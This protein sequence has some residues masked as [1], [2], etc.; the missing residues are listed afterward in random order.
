MYRT[1]FLLITVLSIH[2]LS[3]LTIAKNKDPEYLSRI[4]KAITRAD[5]SGNESQ[6]DKLSKRIE[7]IEKKIE[8]LEKQHQLRA[9][10]LG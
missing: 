4:N 5:T 10:P 9:I 2:L 7:E 6:V 3:S 1:L 8:K